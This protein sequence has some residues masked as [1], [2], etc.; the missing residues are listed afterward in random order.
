[1]MSGSRYGAK[2]RGNAACGG[3]GIPAFGIIGVVVVQGARAAAAELVSEID[4]ADALEA[5]HVAGTLEWLAS[6]APVF[7]T[8]PP[9]TPPRHLVS[10]FVPFDTASRRVLLGDHVKAGLWLPP[11]GHCED[12]EDPRDT[13]TR[14]AREELAV[15]AR[16]HPDFGGG[17][18]FFL[19]VTPTAGPRGHTDVSLWFVLDLRQDEPL[20][21]DP[22]EYHGVR[23]HG[24]GGD[25]TTGPYDPQMGRFASKIVSVLDG[26]GLALSEIGRGQGQGRPESRCIDRRGTVRGGLRRGHHRCRPRSAATARCARASCARASCA[27][28]SCA[29][30]SAG[31]G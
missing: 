31:S 13:V 6:G 29:R 23:W 19:T 27:R 2:R 11:G 22:R 26:A 3:G 4:P 28:A 8:V 14:E 30:A 21:P 24:I 7:R 16:F 12:G 10:Y 1:M 18:P 5:E 15:E 25:F 17:R 9:D 20:T